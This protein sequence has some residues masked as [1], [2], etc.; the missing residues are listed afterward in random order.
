MLVLVVAVLVGAVVYVKKM[1]NSNAGG[2]NGDPAGFENPM[3][4]CP[5]VVGASW[6]LSRAWDD[7]PKDDEGLAAQASLRQ[8]RAYADIPH[9]DANPVCANPVCADAVPCGAVR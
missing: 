9:P 7:L 4:K 2:R 1:T 8:T 5:R 3:C 6:D